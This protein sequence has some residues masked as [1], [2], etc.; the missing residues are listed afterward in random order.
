MSAVANDLAGRWDAHLELGFREIRGQTVLERRRHRGPLRVQKP[1]YPGDGACHVYI[2]HPPGGVVG[3]DALDI[4][5]GCGAG[6][7]VLA[8]APAAAK[9]YRSAGK[10]SC[11]AQRFRVGSRASL[12]WLPP[13][14]I[15]FGASRLRQRTLVELDADARF[16]GWEIVSLGRPTSGD[17]YTSGTFSQGIDIHV[18][19][20]PLLV[21]R[22][23]WEDADRLLGASWGL[24][25]QSV[26]AGSYAYPADASTLKR[27]RTLIGWARMERTAATLLDGL[28]VVRA[29]GD[30]AVRV[31]QAM[32]HLW[33][34]LR[35][36]VIG[37]KPCPPRIWAT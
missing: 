19:G 25:G 27:V 26:L 14:T 20:R 24:A 11:I 30:D 28:L 8:T 29:L 32:R 3:G 1:F 16:Y 21:E 12:E 36:A 10:E 18:D 13:D 6:T 35:A 17:R 4:V 7:S 33:T 5:L 15:L 34:G 2:L 23:R 22:Q 31:Q 37:R 9:V